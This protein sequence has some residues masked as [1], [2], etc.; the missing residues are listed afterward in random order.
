MVAGSAGGRRGVKGG[1]AGAARAWRQ[2]HAPVSRSPLQILSSIEA[3]GR[4]ASKSSDGRGW[5]I[6]WRDRGVPHPYGDGRDQGGGRPDD[7]APCRLHARAGAPVEARRQSQRGRRRRS[8]R[9]AR[10]SRWSL[11]WWWRSRRRRRRPRNGRGRR[12]W[13]CG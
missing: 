5:C 12:R 11:R 13:R 9:L 6:V 2:D 4:V 10:R 3:A 1:G 7:V 8:R